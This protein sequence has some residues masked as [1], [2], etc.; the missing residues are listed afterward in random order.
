M[1]LGG[2]NG[3]GWLFR[4]RGGGAGLRVRYLRQQLEFWNWGGHAGTV[5]IVFLIWVPQETG[6]YAAL[7]GSASSLVDSTE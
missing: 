6:A 1:G 4:G 5:C 2:V 7:G 3:L